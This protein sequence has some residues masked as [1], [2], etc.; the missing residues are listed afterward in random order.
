MK[1]YSLSVEVGYELRSVTLT[2][3]ELRHVRSGEPL[4]KTVEDLYEGDEYTFTFEFNQDPDYSLKVTYQ[5]ADDILTAGDG[6]L[7][8][9]EDACLDE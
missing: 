8:D 9:I 3:E 4:T 2:E 1:T 7:G 5:Q 6:F